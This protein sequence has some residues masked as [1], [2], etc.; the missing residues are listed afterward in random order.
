[1]LLRL[2]SRNAA[3]CHVVKIITCS[4]SSIFLGVQKSWSFLSAGL[5][6]AEN[7]WNKGIDKLNNIHIWNS[8]HFGMVEICV[9]C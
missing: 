7:R 3:Q 4:V 6:Q 1:M 5:G 9:V 2:N 8:G